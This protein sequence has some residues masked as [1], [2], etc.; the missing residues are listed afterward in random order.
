MDIAIANATAQT[1]TLQDGDAGQVVKVRVSFTDDRGNH[2]TLTSTPTGTVLPAV[3]TEPR[4]LVV[5]ALTG[6][7][8]ATWQVPIS[9]GGAAVSG[10]RV[11]WK[12]TYESWDTSSS[13]SEANTSH[14]ITGVTAGTLYAVRVIATNDA[15]DSP[16]SREATG[17]PSTDPTAGVLPKIIGTAISGQ[18]LSVDTQGI[19]D[20]YSLTNPSF[21]YQWVKNDGDRSANIGGATASTYTPFGNDLGKIISVK[22]TFID[23]SDSSKTLNQPADPTGGLQTQRDCDSGRRPGIRGRELQRGHRHPDAKHRPTC[24]SGGGLCQRVRHLS[25]LHAL[26]GGAAHR[27]I[28]IPLRTGGQLDLRSE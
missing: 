5:L 7:L 24:Q 23:N 19:K 13:V 28:S 2:E 3:A 6:S 26:T 8:F 14:T 1:Y 11:Q 15:G 20:G 16:P 10:Y 25:D 21:S 9:D 17:T 18:A 22:V 27:A 12:P 4:G